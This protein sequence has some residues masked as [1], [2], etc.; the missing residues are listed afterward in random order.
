MNSPTTIKLINQ[1]NNDTTLIVQ[2]KKRASLAKLE[3]NNSNNNNN[4]YYSTNR[5]LTNVR[6]QHERVQK[7]VS[8]SQAF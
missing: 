6:Q 5:V 8:L 3:N 1:L 7:T 2:T 4:D